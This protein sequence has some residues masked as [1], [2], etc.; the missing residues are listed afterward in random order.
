MQ[1]EQ[2]QKKPFGF[3]VLRILAAA[4]VLVLLFP[5]VKL[6]ELVSRLISKKGQDICI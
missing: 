5:F 4:A 6:V 3:R 2:A 1:T